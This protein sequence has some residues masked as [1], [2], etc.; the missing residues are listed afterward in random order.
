MDGRW[1][2]AGSSL[3]EW[4]FTDKEGEKARTSHAVV[5]WSWRY[6]CELMFSLI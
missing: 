4:E 3:L 2:E 1:Q 5:D 6:Q